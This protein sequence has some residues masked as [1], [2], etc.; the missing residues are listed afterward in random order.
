[1]S[2][3]DSEWAA[4]PDDSESESDSESEPARLDP[5]ADRPGRDRRQRALRV[6]SQGPVTGTSHVTGAVTDRAAVTAA[7]GP[8]L[9]RTVG[10]T[11]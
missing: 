6:P 11:T 3:S 1:M 7:G 4:G 10:V 8:W 5:P 9:G 2:E